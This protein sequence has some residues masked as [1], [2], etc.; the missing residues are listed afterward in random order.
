MKIIKVLSNFLDTNCYLLINNEKAI[1]IDPCV[2]FNLLVKKYNVDINAC[3]LTHGHIDHF[4]K[5][6][7]FL[8]KN[9]SFYLHK[10]TIIKFNDS[11]KNCSDFVG[12][13]TTIDLS[14]E[15]IIKIYDSFKFEINGLNIKTIATPGHT[16][17]SVSFVI[18]DNLFSGDALFKDSIGRVDLPTSN[19]LMM[20]NTILLFKKMKINYKVYPGHG[21]DTTL[22]YEK[23]NN[24]Y[25][26]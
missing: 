26:R 5:I 9:I 21:E 13:K 12:E 4:Y 2:D 11:Y 22:D 23:I 14:N 7:T 24:Q 10:D 25:F 20:N 1:V 17:D 18:E 3:L 8:N 15:N 6:K 19:P 16:N